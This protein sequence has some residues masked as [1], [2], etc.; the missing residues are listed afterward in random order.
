MGARINRAENDPCCMVDR[1]MNHGS[2]DLTIEPDPDNAGVGKPIR[3]AA[4]FLA[5]F[6]VC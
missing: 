4:H 3:E 5:A 1:K 2:V 6:L